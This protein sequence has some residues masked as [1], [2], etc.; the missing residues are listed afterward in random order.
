MFSAKTDYLYDHTN[1]KIQEI[2]KNVKLKQ[3]IIKL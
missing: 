2:N 1:N 3:I